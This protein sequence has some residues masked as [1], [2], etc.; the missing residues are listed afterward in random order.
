MIYLQ[1][2]KITL[3]IYTKKITQ[4]KLHILPLTPQIYLRKCNKIKKIIAKFNNKNYNNDTQVIKINYNYNKQL[5]TTKTTTQHNY[6]ILPT[7]LT[8]VKRDH[9]WFLL[10]QKCTQDYESINK[11]L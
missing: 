8:T 1:D 7:N 4:H 3:T 9:E 10:K 11:R 6:T 5:L 2:A